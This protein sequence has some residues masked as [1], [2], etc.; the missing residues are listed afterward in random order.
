MNWRIKKFVGKLKKIY[1]YYQYSFG[2]FTRGTLFEETL[3]VCQKCCYTKLIKYVNLSVC[4]ASLVHWYLEWGKKQSES[5]I[6]AFFR[7][8]YKSQSKFFKTINSTGF[9]LGYIPTFLLVMLIRQTPLVI[10]VIL[11][12][13]HNNYRQIH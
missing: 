9:T 10:L 8:V 11:K 3:C 12:L 1:T 2:F 7:V 5:Q 4:I 6:L 13:L